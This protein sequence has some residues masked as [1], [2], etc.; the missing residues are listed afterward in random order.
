MKPKKLINFF[1]NT[2]KNKSW[3]NS[4]PKNQLKGALTQYFPDAK[5][6][7]MLLIAKVVKTMQSVKNKG[8]KS[9]VSKK[10][11]LYF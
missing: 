7:K 10:K 6:P 4:T 5:L 1:F 8:K 9:E 11:G 3:W 2:L